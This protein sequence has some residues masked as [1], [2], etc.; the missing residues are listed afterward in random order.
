MMY[1]S[2]LFLRV[3]SFIYFLRNLCP[4]KVKRLFGW[5]FLKIYNFNFYVYVYN[6]SQRACSVMPTPCNSTDCNLP[7]SSVPGIL[8]VRILE[9]VG[10]LFQGIFLT[11]GTN[12][13][14]WWLLHWQVDSLP[15]CHRGSILR[16]IN[17]IKLT[18]CKVQCKDLL[19]PMYFFS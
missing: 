13:P 15:L 8:Q 6:V 12:P 9:W 17:H 11:Q 18:L 4:V 3:G 7:G 10:F 1:N 14:S 5:L 16:S 19:P 2:F